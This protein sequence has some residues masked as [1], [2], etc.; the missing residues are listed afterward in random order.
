MKFH[1]KDCEEETER[2]QNDIN[3]SLFITAFCSFTDQVLLVYVIA[4]Y[5]LSERSHTCVY[6]LLLEA[7]HSFMLERR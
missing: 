3:V 7:I 2:Y 4:D 6:Y 1:M 5:R